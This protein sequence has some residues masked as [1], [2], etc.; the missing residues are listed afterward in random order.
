MKPQ[1]LAC[2]LWRG[3]FPRLC[4]LVLMLWNPLAH[5]DDYTAVNDLLR[6]GQV[7]AAMAKADEYLAKNPRDPQ[8][9]FLRGL[10]QQDAGRLDDAMTTYAG[11]ITDYPELPE[12]YNNIAVLY[13]NMGEFDKARDALLMAIRN[14]QTYSV[15]HENLGD[16]Y[17][18]LAGQ[19][20]QRAQQLDSRNTTVAPKLAVI[21]QMLPPA[22]AARPAAK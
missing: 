11:L 12:P 19:S 15:A 2:S 13:A 18:R 21:R 6:T 9:R 22:A 10:I 16:V 20:Y 3:S 17:M 1:T 14:K 7:Q 8:M 5:A 4:M